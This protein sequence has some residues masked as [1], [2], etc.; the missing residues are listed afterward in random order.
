MAFKTD[1]GG[2]GFSC[3]DIKLC[4]NASTWATKLSQLARQKG[5]V[6]ILTYSLPSM[7]YIRD[8]IGRRPHDIHLI[9]CST[10]STSYV[11]ARNIKEEFPAVRIALHLAVHS[12]V[13]LIAPH[14]VYISSANF[15]D[16]GWHETAIGLHSEQ[17][18]DFM[19]RQFA[20]L[21]EESEEI[22]L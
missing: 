15:G 18:H 20:C 12:K 6:R 21:W 14:T 10:C 17:A 8:Q 2:I 16:S 5:A 19:Q 1:G 22:N 3:N 7:R 11:R 13:L 4:V 9:A